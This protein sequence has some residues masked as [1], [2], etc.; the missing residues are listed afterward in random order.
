M[1]RCSQEDS[2]LR[3]QLRRLASY[4][5]DHGSVRGGPRCRPWYAEAAVLQTAERADAH[6]RLGRTT[7]L[8][9]ATAWITTRL[10]ILSVRPQYPVKVLPPHLRGVNAAL[11]C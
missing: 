7:G 5:L 6:V 11:S 4:P 8:E 3:C 1:S 9:P 2:N 10:L